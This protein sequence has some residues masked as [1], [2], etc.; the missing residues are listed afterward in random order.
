LTSVNVLIE[1]TLEITLS[2]QIAIDLL[3]DVF[4]HFLRETR[5]EAAAFAFFARFLLFV[6]FSALALKAS[7]LFTVQSIFNTFAAGVRA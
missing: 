6:E 2:F 5:E 4:S 1:K 3:T 7:H